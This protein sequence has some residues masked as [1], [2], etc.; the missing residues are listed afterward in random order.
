MQASGILYKHLSN[1]MHKTCLI[2]IS[3]L[4]M[5]LIT[6]L[7]LCSLSN[8][9]WANLPEFDTSNNSD[10]QIGNSYFK[11][12]L[13]KPINQLGGAIEAH[14]SNT[15]LYLFFNQLTTKHIFYEFRA[16]GIDDKPTTAPQAPMS[17]PTTKG[18][19]V[20]GYGAAAILGYN[21]NVNSNLSLLPYI[22]AQA[23]T[24][25]FTSY[26]DG[27]NNSLGSADYGGSIGAKLSQ[28]ITEVFAIY[29]LGYFGYQRSLVA[30]EGVFAHTNQATANLYIAGIE[31]GAP[32]KI[33]Q[34]VSITSYAQV[35]LANVHLNQVAIF[36]NGS[37]CE[38]TNVNGIFGIKVGY[39]F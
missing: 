10:E 20:L 18:R 31:F 5:R 25:T 7:T 21:I 3:L 26:A 19:N 6:L 23:L 24:N 36:L 4:K 22:R 38:S 1:V 27:L 35:M 39:E 15:V 8:L 9:G 32:Y 33:N 34:R 30:S 28:R 12:L 37:L 11:S 29:T 16:Y 2:T 13:S 17:L 14:Q